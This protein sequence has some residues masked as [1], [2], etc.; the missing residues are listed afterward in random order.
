MKQINKAIEYACR[1]VSKGIDGG[2]DKTYPMANSTK[3]LYKPTGNIC[4]TS[5]F[6]TGMIWLAYQFTGDEKYK[7]TATWQAHDFHYRIENKIVVGHHDMGFL[8]SPSCVAAY[9]ITGDEIA[10]EAAIM[11]ADNLCERFHEKSGFIQAWGSVDG[12][13][14][15]R[16]IIDCLMNIPLLFWATSVT[17]NERY[18]EIAETHLR[19]ALKV[20]IRDDFTTYHTYFF[21]RNTNLPDH[22]ETHQGYSDNSIWARGQ[23]WGIYGTALGYKHTGDTSLIE[24]FVNV[25]KVFIEHLPEDNVPAWDMIFTD[26]ETLKDTSA[27]V[28]AVCGILE[29]A[30]IC[31][32]EEK[33][34]FVKKAHEMMEALSG[35]YVTDIEPKSTGI[36]AHGVYAYPQGEGIDECNL[37]GD[38][39]YM[40]ALMLMKNPNWDSYWY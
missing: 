8:Y 32:F 36:L 15:Y 25:T 13:E 1:Q 23:A 30:R 9:K 37:W 2:F 4:W 29:M 24:K 16:L 31:D 34:Y 26:S 35:Y 22:G 10:K 11:A 12:N 14:N 39:Y 40:E 6:W 33:E 21:D 27:A 28:V 5:G 19:T 20:V 3:N 17:G 38:Y 18:G 7:R